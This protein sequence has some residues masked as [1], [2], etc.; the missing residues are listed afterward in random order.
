[1]REEHYLYAI[2]RGPTPAW[3]PPVRGVDGAAV[4][5]CRLDNLLVLESRLAGVPPATPQRLDAHHGV[6]A[7]ALDADALL[8]FRYGVTVADGSLDAWLAERRTLV[9]DVL[10][11]VCGHVEMSVKILRLDGAMAEETRLREIA[12]RLVECA[13]VTQWRR[14]PAGVSGNVAGGVAFL[15]AREDVPGFLARIAPV[16]SRARGLAV[17]PTGPWPAYSFVPLLDR[18]PLARADGPD[19]PAGRLAEGGGPH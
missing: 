6:V 18:P 14:R 9:D 13:A 16:A 19:R 4:M 3:R 1:M 11:R 7:S 15:V 10:E 2:V 12:D 5:P 8:P 17:V